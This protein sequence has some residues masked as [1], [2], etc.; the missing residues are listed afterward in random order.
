MATGIGIAAIRRHLSDRKKTND[1]FL[2]KETL[3]ACVKEEIL[4]QTTFNGHTINAEFMV[5]VFPS[6]HN[7]QEEWQ[8]I[9]DTNTPY[10]YY[11]LI[12]LR[13]YLYAL[14][15]EGTKLKK[16]EQEFQPYVN[17]CFSILTPLLTRNEYEAV[18]HLVDPA[19]LKPTAEYLFHESIEDLDSID[20]F[21]SDKFR[22][23]FGSRLY[24]KEIFHGNFDEGLKLLQTEET[25]L[26][27]PFFLDATRQLLRED[28]PELAAASFEKGMKKQ[29]NIVRTMQLP[30]QCE[31]ALYYV[32]ILQTQ[33]SEISAPIIQR[34]IASLEKREY[35]PYDIFFFIICQYIVNNKET[36]KQSS[37]RLQKM[38]LLETKLELCS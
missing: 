27:H 10:Y 9:S 18:L 37:L 35:T 34:I 32:T 15:F 28:N 21:V 26:H 38:I 4:Q 17:S 13:N 6:I 22:N 19:V 8:Q 5:W 33:P 36:I 16:R 3:A 29:R 2:I 20:M 14:L 25:S 23:I 1:K 31:Y 24:L 30:M 7:M 11:S 12:N